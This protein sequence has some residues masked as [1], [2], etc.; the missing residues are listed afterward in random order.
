M[1]IPDLQSK[2]HIE[3]QAYLEVIGVK[4]V[5]NLTHAQHG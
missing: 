5:H 4:E 2:Q 1:S 3:R